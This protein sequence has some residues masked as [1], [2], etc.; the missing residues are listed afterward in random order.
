MCRDTE[1]SAPAEYPPEQPEA[2]IVD[3]DGATYG[4]EEEEVL[5]EEDPSAHDPS[6]QTNGDQEQ[7]DH[8]MAGAEDTAGPSATAAVP[9]HAE[10]KEVDDG[11]SDAGSEDLEAESSGSEDEE[12]DEEEGDGEGEGEVEGEGEADEDMEMGDDGEQKAGGVKEHPLGQT[13]NGEVMVH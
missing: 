12:L 8:E 6:A 1:E 3:D 9:D 11:A 7:D 5:D 13:R 2:D 10:H 4:A